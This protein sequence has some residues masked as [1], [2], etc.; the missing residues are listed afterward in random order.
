MSGFGLR[1]PSKKGP[2]L[3]KTSDLFENPKETSTT[4][5]VLTIPVG[6]SKIDARKALE[7]QEAALTEDAALFDYDRVYDQVS[8]TARHKAQRDAERVDRRP[9]YMESIMAAAALRKEER[10][11]LRMQRIKAEDKDDDPQ[12]GEEVFITAAYRSKLQDMRAKG[13]DPERMKRERG[14][15]EGRETRIGDKDLVR[16]YQNM[17]RSRV[18]RTKSPESRNGHSNI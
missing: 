10:E 11:V 4:S 14:E 9:K 1:I 17:A 16:F 3:Q 7:L 12:S 2:G 8:S 6:P 13:I 5:N 18:D 15:D